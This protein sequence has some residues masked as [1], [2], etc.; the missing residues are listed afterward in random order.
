V[1]EAARAYET[2]ARKHYTEETLPPMKG[3]QRGFNFPATEAQAQ[4]N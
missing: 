3:G 1:E 4:G 2:Q